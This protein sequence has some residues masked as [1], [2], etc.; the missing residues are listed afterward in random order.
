MSAALLYRPFKLSCILGSYRILIFSLE[1]A[2]S[3]GIS[4]AVSVR[5]FALQSSLVISALLISKNHISRSANLV[6]VFNMEKLTTGNNILWK[7]G[8]IAPKELFLLFSTI[9]SIYL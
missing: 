3:F 9:F 2:N 8:E 7:R 6:P 1:P 5:L 4:V